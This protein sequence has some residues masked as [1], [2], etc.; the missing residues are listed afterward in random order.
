VGAALALLGVVVAGCS[1]GTP[2]ARPAHSTKTS[3][4][5]A[6]TTLPPT[7]TTTLPPATTTTTA[8][9]FPSLIV[10]AMA[11]FNPVPPGAEAPG[12][13]PSVSGYLTAQTGGLGGEDNVTLIATAQP[14]PVNS[15]ALS[16]AGAGQEVASFSTTPTASATTATAALTQA[17]SQ[18]IDGCQGGS[19]AV[20]LAGGTAATSCPTLDG[21]ALN[22][23]LGSWTVQV[24]NLSGTT[25]ATTQADAVASALA[26]AHLPGAT[27]GLISVVVPSSPAAGTSDTAD[28]EWT[29][30]ADLYDVRSTTS[31]NSAISLAT[32]MRSYPG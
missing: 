26:G 9:P 15:P 22:W 23:D 6:T 3:R 25:P 16:S 32:A 19:Q 14:I 29:T 17:K 8:A 13:L 5:K 1:V 24:V 4:V 18:S 27:A 2:S 21:A 12:T 20:T 11:Q 30:G 7:T 10:Q 31:P 28:L